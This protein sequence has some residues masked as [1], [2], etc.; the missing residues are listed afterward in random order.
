MSPLGRDD[1]EMMAHRHAVLT[2]VVLG[3]ATR[4]ALMAPRL[5]AGAALDDP[6]AYL[7]LARAVAEGRGF[8]LPL[9]GRLTAYRP[10]LYPL[11]LAPLQSLLGPDWVGWGVASLHLAL[12][13]ATILLVA[14]TATRWGLGPRRALLATFLVAFDPVLMAQSRSVMTETLAAF[15]VALTLWSASA[16]RP[17]VA[18]MGAGMG[19]GLASLCRPSLLP[20]AGLAT[21]F[22][23]LGPGRR[24]DR[25]IQGFLLV[26][27]TVL[28]LAPWAA[29]NARVFGEPVWTTTHGGHTLALGNNPW[30][31]ADVLDGGMSP[32][33]T[34]PGQQ[35][36][37]SYGASLI[38]GR[39]EPEAS[40]IL[41]AEA[42]RMLR[43][44]PRDFARASLA[45]LG[46]FWGLAP[47]R[48]AYP[49]AARWACALWSLPFGVLLVLGMLRRESWRWPRAVAVALLIGLTVVHSVYWTDLR[50]RAPLVPALALL[51]ASAAVLRSFPG[52]IGEKIR[53]SPVQPGQE[54]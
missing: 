46:R 41:T 49:E 3:V 21:L 39:P 38:W 29:R 15:L 17:R 28:V 43:D 54:R 34:G 13:A 36:W 5:L 12:G 4:L 51:A 1:D 20:S 47:A 32:T 35:A 52:K 19:F 10:P 11:V 7:P 6:D 30:Y 44:R 31:Y 24:C 25:L 50:M 22:L 42:L 14:G 37:F 45:R 27:S 8:V 18:S 33:W 26:G 40:R 2:L 53:N 23:L 16:S 48:G 9:D